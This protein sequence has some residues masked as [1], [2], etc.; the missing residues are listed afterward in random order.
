MHLA[1]C[2]AKDSLAFC[3]FD[4]RQARSSDVAE[5][6]CVTISSV[7][8]VVQLILTVTLN[9]TY[10]NLISLVELSI[11]EILYRVTMLCQLIR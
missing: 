11:R 6:A 8:A 5:T 2:F 3:H 10:I 1:L 9:M 7:I 4:F